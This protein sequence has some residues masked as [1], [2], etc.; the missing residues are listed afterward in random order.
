MADPFAIIAQG[1]ADMN[2][3]AMREQSMAQNALMAMFEM[4]ARRQAPYA[5]MPAEL[6]T[7]NIGGQAQLG[8]SMALAEHKGKVRRRYGAKKKDDDEVATGDGTVS[9][10]ATGGEYETVTLPNGKSYQIPKAKAE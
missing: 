5:A 10:A 1:N 8:R 6:A 2:N 7:A 9:S 3:A 4:E